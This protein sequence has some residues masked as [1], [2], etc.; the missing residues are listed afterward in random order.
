MI[1]S[2]FITRQA[3]D[4]LLLLHVSLHCQSV[5]QLLFPKCYINSD[6]TGLDNHWLYKS[7]LFSRSLYTIIPSFGAKMFRKINR[8]H[9]IQTKCMENI[10][11]RHLSRLMFS[12]PHQIMFQAGCR[13]WIGHTSVWSL[14]L[15]AERFSGPNWR[16]GFVTSDWFPSPSVHVA[17]PRAAVSAD[18]RPAL[19]ANGIKEMLI[20]G[21]S[22]IPP[23]KPDSNALSKTL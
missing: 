1:S 6:E 2:S 11:Q 3:T 4:F 19:G 9:K 18:V 21:Q 12:F 10:V 7:R 13:L 17:F 15:L 8:L 22:D 14:L 5:E 23:P 16:N 20:A